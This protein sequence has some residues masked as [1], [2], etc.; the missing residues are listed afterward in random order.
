MYIQGDNEAMIY[1]GV[2][3]LCLSTLVGNRERFW[4]GWKR[5]HSEAIQGPSIII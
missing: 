5:H 3:L 1:E 4:D 2:W